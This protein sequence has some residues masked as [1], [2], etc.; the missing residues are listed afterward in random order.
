M[1]YEDAIILAIKAHAGQT[2]W[3]GKPYVLHPLR[4]ARDAGAAITGSGFTIGSIQQI[5]TVAVL[6]DVLEDTDTTFEK[7]LPFGATIA[8]SV[9]RLSRPDDLTYAEFIQTIIDSSDEIAMRVKLADL[10]DNLSD[11][12]ADHRLRKRYEPAKAALTTALEGRS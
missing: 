12:P 3:N 9:R 8:N 6:H 5:K 11:L 4:V 7:L 2:R 1:T 10:E